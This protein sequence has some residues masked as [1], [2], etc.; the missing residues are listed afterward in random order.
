MVDKGCTTKIAYQLYRV[1]HQKVDA[2][3]VPGW[4]QMEIM[5]QTSEFSAVKVKL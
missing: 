3:W 1:A 2:T 4:L 5:W